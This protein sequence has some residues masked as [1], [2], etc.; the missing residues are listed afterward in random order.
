MNQDLKNMRDAENWE[1]D[2]HFAI[3][4]GRPL[5]ALEN[6]KEATKL[7]AKVTRYDVSGAKKRLVNL[8]ATIHQ[9]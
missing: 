4:D 9:S 3:E 6:I 7:L 2:A 8:K 1:N 5:D